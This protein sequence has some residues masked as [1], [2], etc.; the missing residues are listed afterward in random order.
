ML[1]L[2]VETEQTHTRTKK[3][4]DPAKCRITYK[5]TKVYVNEP[6]HLRNV[7]RVEKG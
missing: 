2:M 3:K 6:N 7:Q 4:S 1:T 5:Y